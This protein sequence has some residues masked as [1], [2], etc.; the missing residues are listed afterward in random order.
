MHPFAALDVPAGSVGIHWFEQSAYALKDPRG[1]VALVDPYFPHDR[2]PERFLHPEPPLVESELP[3]DFVLLTHDHGDHTD[4]ESARRIYDAWPTVTFVG[5]KESMERVLAETG[6]QIDN[7]DAEAAGET[8]DIG[9]MKVSAVYSKP[10][11][12]D[13]STGIEPPNTPHLGFVVDAASVR[14][15]ISGDLIHTFPHL[16][17]LVEE[18]A[19]LR[20]DIGFLTT[21]PVEDEFPSFDESVAMA[22]RIG[23]KTAC[24]SHYE[25]FVERTYDPTQ[26]AATFPAGGPETLIVPRNSHIVY[27]PPPVDSVQ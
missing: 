25:C 7:T 21:H 8:V 2:P 4:P 1:T 12:G 16:D 27:R 24:P 6:A 10:P 19:R 22:Q 13:P 26:W 15:Y 14:V 11:Q 5:P 9:T 23:L 18:V 17:E 3:T 20:P